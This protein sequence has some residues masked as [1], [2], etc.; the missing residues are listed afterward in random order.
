MESICNNQLHHLWHSI[1]LTEPWRENALLRKENIAKQFRSSIRSIAKATK[2]DKKRSFFEA[3]K[4]FLYKKFNYI[5]QGYTGRPHWSGRAGVNH[6]QKKNLCTKPC[7]IKENFL[8]AA[9]RINVYYF[10]VPSLRH[11]SYK[12]SKKIP[13]HQL[14][15]RS[16]TS[17]FLLV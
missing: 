14:F 10:Y 9:W 16:W 1:C 7:S 3:A 6:F 13:F 12:Q 17:F 8:S 4:V 11:S 2:W 15:I 5:N